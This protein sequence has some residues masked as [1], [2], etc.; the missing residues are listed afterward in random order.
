[1][2][3]LYKQLGVGEA[4]EESEIRAA[5]STV[6]RG[7][8]AGELRAAEFILLDPARRAVY[9]RNRRVLVTVGRLRANLGLNLSRFWPRSRFA[10]FTIELNPVTGGTG[11][12]VDPM[13]MAWAFGVEP[14]EGSSSRRPRRRTILVAA[15]LVVIAAVSFALWHWRGLL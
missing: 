5:L 6:A 8:A 9:D 13:T 1:M 3:D 14:P 10:D 11:R 4:A 2:K 15:A 12:G 7:A